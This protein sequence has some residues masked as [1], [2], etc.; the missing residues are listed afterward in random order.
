MT[1]ADEGSI[2]HSLVGDGCCFM[3]AAR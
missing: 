1:W 2:C 3:R